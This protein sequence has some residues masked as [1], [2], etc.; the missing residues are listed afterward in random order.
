MKAVIIENCK[1]CPYSHDWSSSGIDCEKVT[2][3]RLIAR[4]NEERIEA[5]IKVKEWCPLPN[6]KY[7]GNN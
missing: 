2:P 3:S 7:E 6:M 5:G 4:T 1:A